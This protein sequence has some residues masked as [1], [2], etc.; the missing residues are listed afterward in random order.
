MQL[1]LDRE[2]LRPEYY[3]RDADKVGFRHFTKEA[4]ELIVAAN[5][6]VFKYGPGCYVKIKTKLP[7]NHVGPIKPEDVKV[8]PI[9]EEVIHVFNDL[10]Q[11]HWDGEGATIEQG[12]VLQVVSL[13]MGISKDEVLDRNYLNIEEIYRE[14][15]W[16]VIYHSQTSVDDLLPWFSFS[17]PG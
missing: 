17:K 11:K 1:Q 15:G 3:L 14:A 8:A 12:K 2:D 6:A 5:G 10:I 7:Q 16:K 9:P 4:M 13:A